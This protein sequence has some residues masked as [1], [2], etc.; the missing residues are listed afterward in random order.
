MV[1][2]G[3]KKTEKAFKRF[4][5]PFFRLF[6]GQGDRSRVPVDPEKVDSLLF[7]RPDKLGDMISTIPAAHALKQRFP[8]LRLEIMASPLNRQLVENDPAFDGVHVYRKNILKDWPLIRRLKAKRFS[9]VFD[10]ICLDSVTG[11][12]LTRLISQGSITAA[13]RKSEMRV[14][15]DYCEPYDPDGNE[16]NIDNGL[17]VF[18]LFGVDPSTVDPFQPVRL[19]ES[20]VEKAGSFMA[21]VAQPGVFTVG[22]NISAGSPTRT[23]DIAKYDAVIET[24]A[25]DNAATRFVIVCTPDDRKRGRQLAAGREKIAHLVPDGLSLLD[26]AAIIGRADLFIS[27]DT[28]LIHMARL[29]KVPVVG[30]YCGQMRNFHSW[31]PYRQRHGGVVSGHEGHI[32]DI[33]AQQIVDEVK[34]VLAETARPDAESKMHS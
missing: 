16:H 15:Y 28:S 32:H 2:T 22:L 31:R 11:L 26:A 1:S 17:L 23:L 33:T 29:M 8:H 3:V 13:S 34:K 7:I 18:N 10:S 25:Q 27:P 24:L 12:L 21:T 4:L 9:V 5:Y 6:F 19:P 20:S 14:F 30:L